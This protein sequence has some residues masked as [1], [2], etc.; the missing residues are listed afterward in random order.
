MIW[1]KASAGP[2]RVLSVLVFGL[3]TV[4]VC[5]A[6]VMRGW[7][8]VRSPERVDH[9]MVYDSAR[10]R[11]VGFGGY[12]PTGLGTSTWE[13]DQDVW[14]PIASEP[15]VCA[16]PRPTMAFDEVRARTVLF[17][18]A[19]IGCARA[20]TWEWD[21]RVWMERV[22]A[23]SPSRRSG[24]AMAYDPLR[25]RIVLFGGQAQ[26][27]LADTWEWDGTNWTLVPVA[28]SP[29]P[30]HGHAMAF[31]EGRGRIVMMGGMNG[32]PLDDIWEW[33]GRSWSQAF[34]RVRPT[35]RRDHSL[36][37]DAAR[38]RL[39]VVGGHGLR[40]DLPAYEVWES[41][42]GDWTMT[43]VAAAPATRGFALAYDRARSTVVL[44][45]GSSVGLTADL[46]G[47]DGIA[48]RRLVQAQVPSRR[49]RH[50]LVYDDARGR[51]IMFGGR[52]STGWSDEHWEWSGG[53]WARFD[54][55]PST[56]PAARDGHAAA[57]DAD[58]GR[59]VM[60]G[61]FT[62]RGEVSDTWEWDGAVWRCCRT[63]TGPP[64]ESEHTMAYDRHR[65]RSLLHGGKGNAGNGMVGAG[66]CAPR[67]DRSRAVARR[68]RSTHRSAVSSCSG[69][70]AMDVST[71]SGSGTAA[72]GR[73]CRSRPDPR[74]SP[75][76]R[77]R[78][79]ERGSAW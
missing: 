29:S 25:R 35:P 46:W 65:R 13:W 22:S 47:W 72:R 21:G 44:F 34:P 33:D 2:V 10:R 79:T 48:W 52:S 40:G 63:T 31:D 56:W 26:A 8:P 74:T 51:V 69:A 58:R 77:W 1:S 16:G 19:G 66:R 75:T 39:V 59:T 28:A 43:S 71:I 70:A 9:A 41:D 3:V 36:V 15:A 20:S 38:R 55:G 14:H 57:Y 30:R 60:F 32:T 49:E 27:E 17:G 62:S 53:S 23:A 67:P 12:G 61:G 64:P 73:S 24:S 50:A 4:P 54:R 6:Q 76:S 11:L 68:W 7:M 45:G 37:Y 5:C 78:T 42:G 18:L